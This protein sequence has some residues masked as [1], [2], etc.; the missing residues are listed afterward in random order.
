[1]INKITELKNKATERANYYSKL[2]FTHL[3]EEFTEFVNFLAEMENVVRERDE[4][5]E[6]ITKMAFRTN[7]QK[8]KTE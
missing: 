1:M 7:E 5:Q 2:D 3:A 8:E 4:L 6:K